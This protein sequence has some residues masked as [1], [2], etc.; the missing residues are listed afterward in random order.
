MYA[1]RSRVGRE[2]Y[3]ATTRLTLTQHPHHL[4][5]LTPTTTHT[6]ATPPTSNINSNTSLT[7]SFT[8][9]T[10]TLAASSS[11]EDSDGRSSAPETENVQ[12]Q[13]KT[14]TKSESE[15]DGKSWRR[16]PGPDAA[17]PTAVSVK[18]ASK[19]ILD[20]DPYPPEKLA[21]LEKKYGWVDWNAM[22]HHLHMADVHFFDQE[23]PYVDQDFTIK[24]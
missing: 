18:A 17:D 11:S 8:S 4:A 7:R 12:G 13:D 19:K 2:V 9:S 5:L 10:T 16:A 14:T 23:V 20:V 15:D 24:P 1:L 3:R 21:A 6:V 22:A